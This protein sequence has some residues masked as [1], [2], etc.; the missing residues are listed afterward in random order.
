MTKKKENELV[1]L[2]F[3][4]DI[5]G[6]SISKSGRSLNIFFNDG[7]AV[8]LNSKK[9]LRLITISIL[10]EEKLSRKVA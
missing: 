9:L 2:D 3:K 10:R 7:T 8:A 5:S 6:I 4:N 1:W